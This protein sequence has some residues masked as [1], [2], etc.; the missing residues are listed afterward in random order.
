MWFVPVDEAP[1]HNLWDSTVWIGSIIPLF[2]CQTFIATLIISCYNFL[3]QSIFVNWNLKPDTKLVCSKRFLFC[4]VWDVYL[5]SRKPN[6]STWVQFLIKT[7]KKTAFSAGLISAIRSDKSMCS[8]LDACRILLQSCY[9]TEKYLLIKI[10]YKRR[11]WQRANPR[12][13]RKSS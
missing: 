6:L 2:W 12:A 11:L 7:L 10:F 8:C 3:V 4:E 13:L 9:I 1:H 5:K